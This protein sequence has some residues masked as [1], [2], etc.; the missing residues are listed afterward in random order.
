MINGKLILAII[1]ARGGSKGIPKKNIKELNGKPLIA[2]TIE[3]TKKSKYVDRIIVST[4]DKQIAKISRSYG[5]DVPFIRPKELAQ[6]DTP[7]IEPIIHCIESLKKNENYTTEYVCLLQC[8]SP[9]RKAE[10]IDEALERIA[11]K[12]SE[13]LVSICESEVSPY[14]MKKVENDAIEDFLDNEPFFSRRQDIPKVYRLNGAL[15]I[16][17]TVFLLD[18]K[19][20]YTKNTLPYIMDRLTSVDID[21]IVDFRFAEFL[22]KEGYNE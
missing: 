2:Y 1:P 7:G 12:N 13:S 20:W 6:D 9:F 10:Q 22:I 11:C 16:A 5:A 14:W 21:D 17:K 19:N 4:D 8:T 15:Y 3:E 18:N